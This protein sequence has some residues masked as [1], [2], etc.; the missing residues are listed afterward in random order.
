MG[1]RRALTFADR[2]EISTGCKAGW[3]V[4]RIAA[5]VGRC[6][7]V[8][9]RE[10]RRNQYLHAGYQSV[11]ADCQAER[12]RARPQVCKVASDPALRERVLADLKRGRSPRA[13]AGRLGAEA[14][15]QLQA[16]VGSPSGH[17]RTVSHEAVYTYI[18][19]MPRS[20]LI[21]HGIRLDSKRTRR[22]PRKT[23]GQRRGPIVGMRS[24]EDRPEEVDDRKVPGSWEGD[25]II[26]KSG[27]TAAATLVERPT[28]FLAILALP[29]G[30]G[31]ESVADAVIDHTSA[32][33][34]LFRKTLTWDQGIEMARH[35]HIAQAADIKIY[36]APPL[37][38]GTWHQRA[39]EPDDPPLHP[40][41]D[42][43][44][45]PPALPGRHRRRT[46]RDPPQGPGLAH[47]QR[48]LRTA[49]NHHCCYDD[50]TLPTRSGSRQVA[51]RAWQGRAPGH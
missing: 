12:K 2:M 22:R 49:P 6:P 42:A 21:A 5:H 36:F 1:K 8:I 46:Q 45:R 26:G 25:L 27:A 28:R 44:H 7:S 41:I 10:I 4:R 17:A 48:S 32:L 43:H 38:L 15:G 30:R 19:A 20:E 40:Q 37:A 24:I 16:T 39:N 33:P 9:S 23:P 47:T 35:A 13:I 29:L 3:T 50:L 31:S 14:T 51:S 34:E 11:H 18:Y